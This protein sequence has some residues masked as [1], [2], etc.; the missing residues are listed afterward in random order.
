M[1][2]LRENGGLTIARDLYNYSAA[3]VPITPSELQGIIG[4]VG[5]CRQIQD[6]LIRVQSI[7]SLDERSLF[8]QSL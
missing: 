7:N 1:A 2:Y 3:I 5:C 4:K 6:F 8:Q